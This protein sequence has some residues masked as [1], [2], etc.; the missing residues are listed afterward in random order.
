MATSSVR[1]GGSLGTTTVMAGSATACPAALGDESRLWAP[2][3]GLLFG[4]GRWWPPPV[5][6]PPYGRSGEGG[7]VGAMGSPRPKSCP[8]PK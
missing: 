2:D 6:R 8:P 7:L 1:I 4:V 3:G 5:T